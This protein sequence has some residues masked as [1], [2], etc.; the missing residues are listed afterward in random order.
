MMEPHADSWWA[1]QQAETGED[2]ELC[3]LG[4]FQVQ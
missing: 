2:A 3:T 4:R 1:E